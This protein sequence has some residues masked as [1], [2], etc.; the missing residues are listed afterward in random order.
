MISRQPRHAQHAVGARALPLL[1]AARPGADAARNVAL[2]LHAQRMEGDRARSR[3]RSGPTALPA[4]CSASCF[5]RAAGRACRGASP[6]TTQRG[7]AM[8]RSARSLPSWCSSRRC[9][10]RAA[11]HAAAA[12]FA[13]RLRHDRLPGSRANSLDEPTIAAALVCRRGSCRVACGNGRLP[14][15]HARI[16][17]APE[18]AALAGSAAGPRARPR[19]RRTHAAFRRARAGAARRFHLHALPDVLRGA[20]LG[21]RAAAAA[22]GAPRSPPAQCA[23][24]R[25]RSTPRATAPDEL[26]AYRARY[27]RDARGLGSRHA[28]AL[29]RAASSWLD[30]FGVVV[31]PDEL[32]G[33]T[34]NAA[35]HVVGPERRLVAI[36]D[37]DDIDGIVND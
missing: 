18:C 11:A 20:R 26:R 2:R 24:S 17:A 16:G 3:R 25:S 4:R 33:Y 27:S 19:R 30:A 36:H 14:G 37:L 29:R 5:S 13:L 7:S 9:A 15:L 32:G 22:P 35:V 23:S 21:V 12:G 28:R 34:H 6:C 10:R 1:S 31:I 8:R